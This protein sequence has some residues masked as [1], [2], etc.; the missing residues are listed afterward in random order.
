MARVISEL[1]AFE[2]IPVLSLQQWCEFSVHVEND[3]PVALTEKDTLTCANGRP[4]SRLS[5]KTR[6]V[7]RVHWRRRGEW[8]WLQQ[9]FIRGLPALTQK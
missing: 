2:I 8:N 3:M 5:A 9:A 7:A 4:R 1:N 6:C